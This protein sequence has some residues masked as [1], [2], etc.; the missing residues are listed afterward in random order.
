MKL[1]VF[2]I[3]AALMTLSASSVSASPA[4]SAAQLSVETAAVTEPVAHDRNVRAKQYFSTEP[5]HSNRRHHSRR[6][7]GDDRRYGAYRGWN[8]EDRRY[9]E[10]R[11]WNRYNSRPDGWRNR[12]CVSVGPIWFCK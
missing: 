11:G 4:T 8:G 7:N 6:W 1:P 12:G 5:R 3:A 10:Y 2:A 9:S